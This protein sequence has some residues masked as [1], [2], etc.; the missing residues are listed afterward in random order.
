MFCICGSHISQQEGRKLVFVPYFLFLFIEKHQLTL[1]Y[2][3]MLNIME[4]GWWGNVYV[5]GLNREFETDESCVTCLNQMLL[6]T[7]QNKVRALNR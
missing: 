4:F 2:A 3:D 7:L 6:D 5:S 1:Q